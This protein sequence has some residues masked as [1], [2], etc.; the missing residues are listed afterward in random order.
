MENGAIFPFSSLEK[1]MTSVLVGFHGV[2]QQE[3]TEA[4]DDSVKV[5]KWNFGNFN[6]NCEEG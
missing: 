3:C 5:E 6:A 1:N 2:Q 4:G